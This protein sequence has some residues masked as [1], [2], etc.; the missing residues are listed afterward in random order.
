MTKRGFVFILLAVLGA[1]TV[2]VLLFLLMFHVDEANLLTL[3]SDDGVSTFSVQ[4]DGGAVL[5]RINATPA[6]RISTIHYGEIPAGFA[7]SV[8]S[9]PSRPR[10]FV[11]GEWVKTRTETPTWFKEH[12]CEATG[13]ETVL[14]NAYSQGPLRVRKEHSPS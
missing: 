5:W 12:E 9:P 3:R 6:R 13:S 11:K 4:D 10:G 2:H 14:C 7:Q 1:A 8:P